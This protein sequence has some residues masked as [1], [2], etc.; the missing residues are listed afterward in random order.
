M[1]LY[2]NI[3]AAGSGGFKIDF[4]STWPL[5]EQ[6]LAFSTN[7]DIKFPLHYYI[8]AI[9]YNIVND[10][11]ILRIIYC[12]LALPIP[13]LFYLCLK[14]KYEKIDINNLFLFSLIIFF[15]TLV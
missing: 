6:P 3:D 15:I 1:D 7:Y 5:V 9:I 2:F 10:K 13:Y 14:I 4:K 11:E 12:I 8:A